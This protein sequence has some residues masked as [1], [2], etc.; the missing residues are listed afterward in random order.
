MAFNGREGGE[1]SLKEGASMT[2]EY[3]NQ[4]PN[5]IKARFFGKDILEKI[6]NQDGCMGIRMYYALSED[7]E[8]QLVLVGADSDEND[9]LDIIADTSLPCPN[10]CSADNPLNS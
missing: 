3:R 1:I 2:S 4:N 8:P 9:M 5:E 10:A 6:L 7:S